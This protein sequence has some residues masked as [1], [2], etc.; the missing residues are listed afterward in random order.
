MKGRIQLTPE[1]VAA[2]DIINDGEIGLNDVIKLYLYFKNEINK[3]EA[4]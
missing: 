3:L 4:S 1:E 2:S